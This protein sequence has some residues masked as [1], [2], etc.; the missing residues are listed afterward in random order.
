V[1]NALHAIDPALALYNFETLQDIVDSRV[2]P[3]KLSVLLL[4]CLAAIA[5]VLA[6]LGTYGVMAYMVSGRTQEIGLRR[7]LGATPQHILRLVLAQ[8]MRVSLWGVSTGVLAALVMGRF[9]G[10]MLS[11]ITALD[12]L[13][14]V[15]V[16]G[17]LLLVSV[18]ACY[19]PARRAVR[20]HPLAAVRHE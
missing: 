15:S 6:S 19:V 12:P 11:G 17:L 2:A 9:V 13:T 18:I 20:L 1:R 4:S 16:G 10:P 7:A 14:F 3:R 8:G 5:L